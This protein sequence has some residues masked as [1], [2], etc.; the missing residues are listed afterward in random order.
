MPELPNMGV[1]GTADLTWYINFIF[2]HLYIYSIIRAS[3]LV[4]PGNCP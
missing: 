4:K 3:I 2:V 1:L